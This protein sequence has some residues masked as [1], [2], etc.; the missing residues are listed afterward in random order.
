MPGITGYDASVAAI[1]KSAL[2]LD[3][4][5]ID[6]FLIH[7]PMGGQVNRLSK[8]EAL[9]KAKDTGTIRSIGV[10]NFGIKH[11]E[12]IRAAGLE[13]PAVNQI[14]VFIFHLF[15]AKLAE[16]NPIASSVFSADRD[17][18]LLQEAWYRSTGILP[19]CSRKTR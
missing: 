10:S 5:Y 9:L 18:K 1:S 16:L 6:L 12:E 14:E 8:W 15:T 2:E 4:G 3:L 13:Q 7:D 11:M 19:N 17:S